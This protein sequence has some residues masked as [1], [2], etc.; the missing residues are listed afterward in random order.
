MGESTVTLLANEIVQTRS[1]K[2]INQIAKWLKQLT[3]AKDLDVTRLA[4]SDMFDVSITLPDG[5]KFPL[6][7]LGYGLSQVLPVLTQCSFAEEESTLLFEQP[8]IHL[9][10]L[11]ARQ[12]ASV[13]IETAKGKNCHVI[14]ETHSPELVKQF[15]QE[16]KK[17]TLSKDD[18][19]AYRVARV[20]GCSS[21]C[22]IAVE[23]QDGEV[24]V[25]EN[26]ESGISIP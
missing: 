5:S 4:S 16:L 25:Y 17:G 23:I 11:A 12:L 13:F 1:R 10:T 19:V 6:A 3:L 22:P 2:H 26:W 24:D 9:H 20:D 18:F 14:V 8:E 21:I 7:D 15:F